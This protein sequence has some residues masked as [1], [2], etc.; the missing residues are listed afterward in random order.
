MECAKYK[1]DDAV[2]KGISHIFDGRFLNYN[3]RLGFHAKCRETRI[4]QG[5][6]IYYRTEKKLSRETFVF[7]VV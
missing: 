6:N 2:S 7:K 1:F 4:Q 3:T 5:V